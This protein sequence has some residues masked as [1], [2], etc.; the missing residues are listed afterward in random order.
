MLVL[1]VLVYQAAWNVQLESAE[2]AYQDTLWV[3]AVNVQN[4]LVELLI[5]SSVSSTQFVKL[6]KRAIFFKL[7]LDVLCAQIFQT[8]K[9]AQT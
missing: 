6:A 4:K 8:V 1:E 9:Y 7:Q 3:R 2:L 5:V